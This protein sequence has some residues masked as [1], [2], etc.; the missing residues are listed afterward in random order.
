MVR[1]CEA[2]HETIAIPA[3]II[4][5]HQK[6]I[7]TLLAIMWSVLPDVSSIG[8]GGNAFI[9]YDSAFGNAAL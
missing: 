9:V 7:T 4:G 3:P 1:K 8:C 5:I 6:T 2:V